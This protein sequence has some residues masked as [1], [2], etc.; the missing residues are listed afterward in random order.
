MP[1][2]SVPGGSLPNQSGE[3]SFSGSS[4]SSGSGSGI[5]SGGA[6]GSIGSGIISGPANCTACPGGTPLILRLDISGIGNP[7]WCNQCSTL[8]GSY[9]LQYAPGA[10]FSGLTGDTCRPECFWFVEVPGICEWVGMPILIYL[11]RYRPGLHDIHPWKLVFIAEKQGTPHALIATYEAASFD[12]AAP[13]VFQLKST[14][15]AQ[16]QVA[17]ARTAVTA[18]PVPSYSGCNFPTSCVVRAP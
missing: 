12:C 4:G 14:L 11:C 15:D 8:N 1:G 5:V 16:V 6:S 17:A 18:V 3:G 10:P 7:A 13:T 2:G 9:L